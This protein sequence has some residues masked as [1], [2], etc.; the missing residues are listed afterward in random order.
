MKLKS[1]FDRYKQKIPELVRKA[2]ALADEV[3]FPIIPGGNPIGYQ[4]PPSAC[5]QEVGRLL[6][7]LAAGVPNAVIGEFGTGAGVGT[8]WLA[9]ALA[10]T[11]RLV[12]AE[13]R[14]DLVARTRKL[15]ADYPNV[16]IRQGN[17]FEVMKDAMPFDLLFID[18]GIRQVLVP[19]RWD[20]FTQMIKVGG[21]IVFDDLTPIE[22]WPPEWD[23]MVDVKREFAYHNPRLLAA[24]VR[25][26]ATQVA[27]IATRIA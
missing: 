3:G 17:C 16:E 10:P 5:I 18:T 23:D 9:S 2:Y 21:K 22:Q 20:E 6:S 19:E 25:T 14:L 26:T 24:E 11:A 27:I 7:V 15:F 8:A 4:G 12:S 1:R 13:V